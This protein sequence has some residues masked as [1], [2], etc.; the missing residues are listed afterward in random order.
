M[1]APDAAT[2]LSSST[3]NPRRRQ[4]PSLDDSIQPPRAKRQRS[5]LRQDTFEPTIITSSSLTK[6][7]TDI[8]HKSPSP[9]QSRSTSLADGL[10]AHLAFRGPKNIEQSSSKKDGTV[11]IVGALCPI[12]SSILTFLF[13][14]PQSRNDHYTVSQLPSVPDQFIDPN[15]G[16]ILYEYC[17][18]EHSLTLYLRQVLLNAFSLL[19]VA[20]LF[21]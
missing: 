2:H 18:I 5:V 14:V 19:N 7:S 10:E 16:E 15:T 20:T 8:E 6:Q 21:C 9:L 13:S 4:R 11:V 17:W 1:F 3:R 12:D